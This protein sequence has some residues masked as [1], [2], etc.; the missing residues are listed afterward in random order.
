M[1][2]EEQ[3]QSEERGV[4]VQECFFKTFNITAPPPNVT[5]LYYVI[6]RQIIN[7]LQVQTPLGL[8][9]FVCK[10]GHHQTKC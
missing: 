6:R 1:M 2:E 5:D 4:Q 7:S 10:T 8:I 9:L 3:K